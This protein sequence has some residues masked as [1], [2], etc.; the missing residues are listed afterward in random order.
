MAAITV[1][2]LNARLARHAARGDGKAG[3]IGVGGNVALLVRPGA[4]AGTWVLRYRDPA[5]KRRDMGLGAYPAVPLGAVRDAARTA[6]AGLRAGVDPMAERRQGRVRARAAAE[7]PVAVRSF[8][9]AAAAVAEAKRPG[10]R[11]AKHARQWLGS[12]EAHAFPVLGDLPVDRVGRA[13]VLRVLTPMWQRTPET[14]RRVRQRIEAVLA[15]A[16]AE[17]WRDGENPA[18]RE[19]LAGHAL[20][21]TPERKRKRHWPALPWP[22][23]GAFMAALAEVDGM[24][25]LALRFAVLTAARSGEV[26]G[27]RWR[28]VDL[29]TRV[30]TIPGERMKARK[31]QRVPLSEAAV[32]VLRL[33][34]PLGRGPDGVV[35]PGPR[36]G[37]ALSDRSLSE[38]VRGMNGGGDPPRWRDHEGRPVVPHG[39]RATFKVWSMAHGYPDPLS[40][41]ALAHADRD[42]VR[43]AYLRGDMLEP[44]ARRPMMEAWAAECA[45]PREDGRDGPRADS[46]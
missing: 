7:A 33:V 36:G 5:G 21:T 43:G 10:W 45:T 46:T 16:R 11:S 31:L 18:G 37:R 14:A 22:R 24:S 15:H 23:V 6:L 1:K 27:M 4:A 44:E 2:E 42:T 12:L 29:R 25:A 28:E 17:G 35:F 39:F 8:R 34:Q 20:L 40:E 19:A 41:L 32:S 3:R 38:V 13:D 26:R 30:W 9:A